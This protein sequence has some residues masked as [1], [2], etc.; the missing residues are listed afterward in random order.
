MTARSARHP[1][2]RVPDGPGLPDSLS[3]SLGSRRKTAL[4]SRPKHATQGARGL[5]EA[6]AH[7]DPLGGAAPPGVGAP[8]Q[9]DLAL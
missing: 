6:A 9:L 7:E 8:P 3:W 5:Q 1:E 2:G 4:P